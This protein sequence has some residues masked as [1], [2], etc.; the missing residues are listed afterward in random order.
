MT[1]R[2][3]Y[4]GKE[5]QGSVDAIW[6]DGEWISWEYI[7]QH[8]EETDGLD[9]DS[10]SDFNECEHYGVEQIFDRLVFLARRYHKETGR[11]LDIWGEL[12]ELYAE[13]QYGILRHRRHAEGSDGRV[14]NDFI[15][16]KTI[17]P[18]KTTKE[19]HVKRSGHFTMLVIVKINENFSFESRIIDR[20]HLPKGT[21]KVARVKWQETPN[22]R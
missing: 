20:K 22:N 13:A 14:M 8:I 6:D 17:S 7:N 16:V 12:G 19:V 4:T 1:M 2:C 3:A 10:R 9:F 21:G 11:Y 5:V 18:G 15:E